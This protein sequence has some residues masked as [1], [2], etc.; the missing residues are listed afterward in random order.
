MNAHDENRIKHLLKQSLPQVVEDAAP[1][2]DLWPAVLRRL[3]QG[4]A[5]GPKVRSM[6][7]SMP[8]FDW[9]LLGGLVVFTA[10]FPATIPVLLYYL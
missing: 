6:Q 2:R 8:W 9:A 10:S 7:W 1:E 5:A 3:D 4:L